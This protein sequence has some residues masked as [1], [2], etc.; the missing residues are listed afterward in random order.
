MF[1]QGEWRNISL[2]MAT[3]RVECGHHLFLCCITI[4]YKSQPRAGHWLIISQNVTRNWICWREI[5]RRRA[6]VKAHVKL[7]SEATHAW[8]LRNKFEA[9]AWH[10]QQEKFFL[11][12]TE[13][14]CSPVNHDTPECLQESIYACVVEELVECSPSQ[15]CPMFWLG[16]NR[17]IHHFM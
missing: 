10:N 5:R 9:K 17:E 13:H 15:K 11:P 6:H 4:K 14:E 12:S 3:W 1:H 8:L 16:N 7:S 2:W